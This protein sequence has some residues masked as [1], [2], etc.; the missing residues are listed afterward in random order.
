MEQQTTMREIEEQFGP[1]YDID[2]AKLKTFR[3][4]ARR[5]AP[6]D[7]A[8]ADAVEKAVLAR[9]RTQAGIGL[10]AVTPKCHCASGTALN[11]GAEIHKAIQRQQAAALAAYPGQVRRART[12]A[13][14]KA[15]YQD[16]MAA[17]AAATQQL[18]A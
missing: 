17:K 12:P 4:K 10:P 2:S 13:Q 15:M 7:P 8:Y 6:Y 11:D 3:A 5:G 16:A 1:T 9:Q 14:W 18:A